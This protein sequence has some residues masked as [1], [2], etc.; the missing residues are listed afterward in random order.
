MRQLLSEAA[1]AIEELSKYAEAMRK[2]KYEGWHLERTKYHD[3]YHAIATM[4]LPEPP[5]V[6]EERE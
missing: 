1:D 6:E 4:P 5:M 3:G 2:L